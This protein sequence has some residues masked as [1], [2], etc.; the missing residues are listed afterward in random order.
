MENFIE[1]LK[2]PIIHAYFLCYN[3]EYI[4]PHLLNYYSKFC[5]KIVIMDNQSTDRSLEIIKNY[6][7]V[8][9]FQYDS[10]GELRDDFYLKLKN[11]LW[12][13]SRGKA[14]Y[15]IVGDADEFIYHPNL[16]DFL[17]KSFRDEVTILKPKGYHMVADTDMDLDPED[18]IFDLVKFGIREKV[19]DKMM[20]FDCNKIDEINFSFGCHFASPKGNIKII[21]DDNFYML[22]YKFLGIKNFV[23]RNG[24]RRERLSQFNKKYGL[25]LYYLYSD[26]ENEEDYIKHFNKRTKI[27]D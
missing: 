25:G 12:K 8:S 7:N 6:E 10:N 2:K 5:E 13:Q 23:Y 3:E 16:S 9:V 22:H 21:E 27:L 15:V 14:D 20:I 17:N 19:L 11:N 18:N 26:K 4:L 24:L 1:S